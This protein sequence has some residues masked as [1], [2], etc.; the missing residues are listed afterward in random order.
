[1]HYHLQKKRRDINR[2][3]ARVLDSRSSCSNNSTNNLLLE[4]Q[5]TAAVP[6]QV[7]SSQLGYATN[8]NTSMEFDYL[9]SEVFPSTQ[10]SPLKHFN[11]DQTAIPHRSAASAAIKS[12]PVCSKP[13]SETLVPFSGF[14]L[15]SLP[16]RDNQTCV[17]RGPDAES[18]F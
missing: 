10:A 5:S 9:N 8:V 15:A 12:P 3:K 6:N 7:A 2:A 1:M 11:N 4:Q 17:G 18:E 16:K 14:G 13:S